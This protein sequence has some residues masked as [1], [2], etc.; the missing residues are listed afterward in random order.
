MPGNIHSGTGQGPPSQVGDH[1]RIEVPSGKSHV[2]RQ[3]EPLASPIFE[4][5]LALAF[6]RVAHAVRR[7]TDEQV[8]LLVERKTFR[9]GP[10]VPLYNFTC[11]GTAVRTQFNSDNLRWMRLND[12]QVLVVRA[13]R[14]AVGEAR[15]R[16]VPDFSH[17]IRLNKIDQ[18]VRLSVVAGI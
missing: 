1:K 2:R 6:W 12:V 9:H 10:R 8:S 17:S 18:P 4:K 11:S 7:E 15:H 3:I 16:T 14:H 5:G 13:E